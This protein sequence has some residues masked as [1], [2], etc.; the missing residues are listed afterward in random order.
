[1]NRLVSFSQASLL[2]LALLPGCGSD[3]SGGTPSTSDLVATCKKVCNKEVSCI[4][5]S[6][7]A[8]GFL[9]CDDICTPDNFKPGTSKSGGTCDYAKVKSKLDSCANVSCDKLEACQEEAD[10]ICSPSDGT[11]GSGGASNPGAGGS[12][13]HPFGGSTT[14]TG[15]GGSGTGT[16]TAD[17]S[18]CDKA[19]A[20]C[21]ALAAAAGQADTS[22]CDAFSKA[23]CES[24]PQLAQA[25]ASVVQSGAA[26]GVAGCK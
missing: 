23:T 6:G 9:N 25:C 22:S 2:L 12:S 1:V 7:P 21:K 8:A 26:S 24:Q 5:D 15:S 19:A 16:G 3:S 13:T 17:C 10:A 14:T 11:S 4:G 20:C 18:A